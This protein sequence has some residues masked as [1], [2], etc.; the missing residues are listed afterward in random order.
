VAGVF[1]T[2]LTLHPAADRP[3]LVAEA[4]VAHL[5][6]VPE[7]LV[8]EIDPAYADTEAL[9][10]QYGI[11][12]EACANA[13]VVRGVR[14][15]TEKHVVCLTLAD[16]RV[17]VNGVVR[18]RLD[19]RKASFSPMD[20]AVEASGMEYGG[21]TPVGVPDDWPIWVD[22]A[23]ADSDW[24]CI[25]SGLRRSKLFLP[26]RALLDLPGAERVDDLAR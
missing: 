13:V 12:L 21:I 17:D 14:A 8:A 10:A 15:G 1:Q 16:R 25:G 6:F 24:V 9:C 3:D 2:S 23:V 26:A 7:A 18:R 4:V 11:P 20:H 5:P 19:V 22:G